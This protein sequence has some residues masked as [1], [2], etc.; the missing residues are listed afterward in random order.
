L[1]EDAAQMG[2]TGWNGLDIASFLEALVA[3]NP[4]MFEG[5]QMF[6]SDPM[7]FQQ[8]SNL[9][10][11]GQY[12]TITRTDDGSGDTATFETTVD[13]AALMASPELQEMMRQQMEMQGQ[14]LSEE[15][16]QE[17]MALSSAM[18]ENSTF[19]STTTIDLNTGHT[20]S[21]T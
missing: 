8:F 4:E 20:T 11:M 9:E 18:L 12:V 10:L 16:L 5:M 7:M 14:T 21:T 3:Q 15:E 17:A 2:L 1:G 19:A 6:G 13:F